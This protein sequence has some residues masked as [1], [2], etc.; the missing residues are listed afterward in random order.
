MN[1][2]AKTH[3]SENKT[4]Y[5]AGIVALVILLIISIGYAAGYRF[6]NF[7]IGKVGHLKMEMP[8]PLTSVFVDD[9]EEAVTSADNQAL[10]IT[11]SPGEHTVIVSKLGYFP[12][13]KDISIP[14]N[15]D[16]TISPL[17]ITQNTSGQ[18]IT[19][20]DKEYASLKFKILTD[21]LPTKLLPRLSNDK[22]A[23]LWIENN[24]IMLKVGDNISKIVQPDTVV[25]NVDFYKNR[26]DV[27]VFATQ[28][29]VYAIESG[30]PGTQNFMPIYKG[31]K[32]T[33]IKA[34]ANSLYILDVATLM[35]V[36]I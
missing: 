26:S 14:S 11:L 12:W 36:I 9:S 5:T 32:P 27:V 29:G 17:F 2:N 10:N 24:A 23:S 8:L 31:Q 30:D 4:A 18:I 21:K 22:T 3:F 7:V 25:R 15:G 35:Q 33:F 28:N 6:N 1:N 13:T 20:K 34:D 19:T 16:V